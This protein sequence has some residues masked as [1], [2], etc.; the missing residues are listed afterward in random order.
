[1]RK[2]IGKIHLWLSMFVG[3]FIVLIGL[4]GS[5]LVFEPEINSLLHPELYKVTEGKKVTYQQALK[6]VSHSFPKGDINRVYTPNAPDSRG[7][8]LF[9]L[10]EGPKQETI[11]VDPG[12]GHIN[13]TVGDKS[14]FN[15]ILYFHISLLLENFYGEN[16]VGIIGFLFFFITLSGIYLWWPGIKKWKSGFKMRRSKN[17]YIK[18]YDVHK[19]IGGVSIPFLLIVSLTG[20]LF[21]YDETIFGWFGLH[22]KVSPPQKNL[23]SKPLPTGKLSLDQLLRIAEKEVPKGKIEQVIIPGNKGKGLSEGAVEIRLS[24]SYDPGNGNIRLWLDQS[25]G[26]IVGKLDPKENSGLLYQI[27]H[28]PLHT[29]SFGGIF[30]KILYAAGGLTPSIL[31]FTGTYMWLYKKKKRNQKNRSV[32]AA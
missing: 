11:Y 1:M 32:H 17:A 20:A 2:V 30:T 24:R 19:V 16:I 6:I 25:S 23:I 12:T 4:T 3:I 21:A 31:M 7:V 15:I 5:L 13:G 28:L 22:A 29:G 10:K 14:F 27:W 9:Q 26:K 8:F 18:K